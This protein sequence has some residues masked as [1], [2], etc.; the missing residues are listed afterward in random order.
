MWPPPPS[1][2]FRPLSRTPSPPTPWKRPTLAN[3]FLAKP[4]RQIDGGAPKGGGPTFRACFFHLPPQFSF[5]FSLSLSLGVFS[6]NFGGVL[7]RRDP[8][9]CTFGALRVSCEAAAGF[10]PK[11]K[12]IV[13]EQ[14]ALLR[15]TVC[16]A[17]FPNHPHGSSTWTMQPHTRS[18]RDWNC[19]S[20]GVGRTTAAG[21]GETSERRGYHVLQESYGACKLLISGPSRLVTFC[22]SL[23]RG[24]ESP[25]TK[26]FEELKRVNSWSNRV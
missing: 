24:V 18:C 3:P 21:R 8:Q 15:L 11:R 12:K 13:A 10:G 5:F 26:D 6:W 23:A 1:S 9:M 19:D 2:P 20:C 25:T 17:R 4:F 22:G 7:K 14:S 16:N